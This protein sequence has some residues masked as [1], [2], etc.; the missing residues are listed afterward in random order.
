MVGNNV[1]RNVT[2][3]LFEGNSFNRR[4]LIG[5]FDIMTSLAAIGAGRNV[6]TQ[7]ARFESV[8]WF[9][10]C[11]DVTT[12][13]KSTVNRIVRLQLV[14]QTKKKARDGIDKHRKDRYVTYCG[15]RFSYSSLIRRNRA[16]TEWLIKK[17][18]IVG[19]H[20][21][22]LRYLCGG[23]FRANGT[24]L[25]DERNFSLN[26]RD[27]KTQRRRTTTDGW[28][29]HIFSGRRG[30]AVVEL[31]LHFVVVVVVVVVVV[32]WE[33]PQDAAH[34]NPTQRERRWRHNSK[35]VSRDAQRPEGA[36]RKRNEWW[37]KTERKNKP[38]ATQWPDGRTHGLK[39]ATK[40]RFPNLFFIASWNKHTHTKKRIATD[41]IAGQ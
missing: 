31:L 19:N 15:Y 25:E 12:A 20:F 27:S 5:S 34:K 7:R 4:A 11:N 23:P 41:P 37:K 38:A 29:R 22:S 3:S 28:W 8:Y 6:R 24:A 13:N 16:R 36:K 14:F 32:S 17:N 2:T 40:R 30:G 18:K 33:A 39:T 1:L 21:S 35:H 9:F 10:L 26:P